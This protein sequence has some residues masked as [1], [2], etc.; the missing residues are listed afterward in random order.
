MINFQSE[1]SFSQQKADKRIHDA[2]NLFGEKFVNSLIAIAL[3]LLGGKRKDI[4]KFLAWPIG[5]LF[6]LLTRFRHK[7]VMA[8]I[9]QRRQTQD[10]VGPSEIQPPK[11]YIHIIYNDQKQQILISPQRNE[12]RIDASNQVQLKTIILTFVNA[13]LLTANQASE[14]LGLTERRVHQ[15]LQALQQED[16]SALIDK[17]QGQQ[18][19]YKVT[20]AVKSELI[21]QVTANIITGR[22]TASTQIA[23]QLNEACGCNV[24]DRWVRHYIKTL[25]LNLIKKSLPELIDK[26]KKNSKP[27]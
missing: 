21:Q 22:S 13:E 17:R 1:I 18:Q 16:V 8:F 10:A 3:F 23:K 9:D 20:E 25:G 12:L 19:D 11:N 15:L 4:C 2:Q 26:L 6:S 14:I 24:S 5:T 7:G 27:L